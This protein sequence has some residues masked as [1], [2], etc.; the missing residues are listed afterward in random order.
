MQI[1]TD[2]IV[3]IATASGRGGIGIIRLSGAQALAI[4]TKV[5]GELPK[6]S[7]VSVRKFCDSD[8]NVLDEGVVLVYPKPNSFTG[9]DVVELQG[10]GGPVVLD[11]IVQTCLAYGARV[12]EPGEFSK[13]AFLNNK[14]DL[15]QAEAIADL[16]DSASQQAARLAMR[17][18]QGDF[19]KRVH[20]VVDELIRLRVYVEAA[21]DFPEEEIDFLK[22][23]TIQKQIEKLLSDLDD[24][25][26]HAEQGAL[27]REGIHL[28]I[29]GKPN[30]GKSTLLN[31]LSGRE[32]AI[33]TDIPGTTRDVMREHILLDGMPVHVH[34]TAGLRDSD[35]VV[36]QEGIKR[37]W[38]TLDDA[39]HV[40]LVVDSA[41][42]HETQEL[43]LELKRQLTKPFTYTLAL[44]KCDLHMPQCR[45][46]S[47]IAIS[48]KNGTGIDKLVAHI[49]QSVGYLQQSEGHYLAR[50]RH[51][52]KLRHA[53]ECLMRGEQHLETTR[54]GELLAEECRLA[55]QSL[56]AITGEFT[57][58]DLL[59]E[60]F[61]SFCIGK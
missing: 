4:A 2:T 24:I 49:K 8:N 59:G 36:E 32:V 10:H 40:L 12:A 16:I 26:M 1:N 52:I 9:E 46:E 54:A 38:Q 61:S 56:N 17:S 15:A 7:R 18:L 39:D 23:E 5:V 21:L 44:N 57:S 58:D 37:A 22:D 48:A 55:Q 45:D 43:L 50:R 34:D 27:L 53:A 42:E 30:A 41:N 60:I 3:A 33:V 20:T 6:P 47:A 14:I 11:S 19:S 25:L 29:A 28:V 13:R 51:L 31:T 35:D